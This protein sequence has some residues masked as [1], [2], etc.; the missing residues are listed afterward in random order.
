M[1]TVPLLPESR[2][3]PD[4]EL[5]RCSILRRVAAVAR[6]AGVAEHEVGCE[7]QGDL[8]RLRVVLT[9][10]AATASVRHALGVRV[11]DAVHADGRTF[12]DV[13]VD[14]RCSQAPD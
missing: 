6:S 8:S 13:S 7:L 5:L 11:L 9:A 12:G 2:R 10:P 1:P 4:L 14:L 3:Q